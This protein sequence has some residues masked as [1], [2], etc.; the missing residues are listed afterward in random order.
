MRARSR[1]R[2]VVMMRW[3]DVLAA[4]WE[5]WGVH[6]APAPSRSRSIPSAWPDPSAHWLGAEPLAVWHDE[7]SAREAALPAPE[8]SAPVLPALSKPS[9]ESIPVLE[10]E[11]FSDAQC[12]ALRTYMRMCSPLPTQSL[13]SLSRET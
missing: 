8:P 2:K 9:L 12:S 7:T 5:G 13:E 4:P 11:T 6:W 1:S 10:P 3:L